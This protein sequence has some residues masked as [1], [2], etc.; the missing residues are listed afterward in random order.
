MQPH[1]FLLV[2]Y[3]AAIN[4]F[5]YLFFFGWNKFEICKTIQKTLYVAPCAIL[6]T[7]NIF[8]QFYVVGCQ[9]VTKSYLAI[10]HT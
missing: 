2:I 8:S 6:L 7:C 1:A 5:H 3:I 4:S 10:I 9:T